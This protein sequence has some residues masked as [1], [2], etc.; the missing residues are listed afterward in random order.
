MAKETFERW[1]S[2]AFRLP[3]YILSLDHSD[4]LLSEYDIPCAIINDNKNAVQAINKGAEHATGDILI[5][6]SDDFDCP[7]NWDLKL[8]E[9]IDERHDFVLRIKDGLQNYLVT[10]PIMDRVYYERFGYIYYPE[11]QHMFCDTELTCVAELLGKLIS[12]NLPFPHNHYSSTG[13]KDQVSMKADQTWEQGEGLFRSRVKRNFDLI[14][15]KG[16]I[17]DK[18]MLNWIKRNG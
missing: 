8:L 3:E 18:V 4:P 15:P 10:M 9:V 17:T 5:V 11:Y 16:R 2:K 12:C 1:T 7:R 13:K 14:N 6:V